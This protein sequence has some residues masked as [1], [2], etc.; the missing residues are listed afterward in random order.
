MRFSINT[1]LFFVTLIIISFTLYLSYDSY[2]FYQKKEE[3][4]LLE[5]E[6]VAAIEKEESNRKEL[7]T[8]LNLLDAKNALIYFQTIVNVANYY[9]TSGWYL[10]KV[11]YGVNT[12]TAPSI[13]VMYERRNLSQMFFLG[14]ISSQLANLGVLE[15]GTSIE[16]SNEN[17]TATLLLR[18]IPSVT[19][20]QVDFTSISNKRKVDMIDIINNINEFIELYGGLG[21]K[22]KIELSTKKSEIYTSQDLNIYKT[23]L[24][25]EGDVFSLYSLIDTIPINSNV[26]FESLS[27]DGE[28]YKA[29]I[30]IIYNG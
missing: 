22:L 6:R 7:L 21:K 4:N 19:L 13:S 9:E 29:K 15:K 17:R 23:T 14:Y 20:P 2:V 16:L 26:F 18:P 8:Y 24:I 28:L 3:L 25:Y 10:S 5:L 27:F 1:L 11:K 12:K 30:G